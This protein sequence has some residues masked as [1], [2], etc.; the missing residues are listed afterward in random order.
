MTRQVVIGAPSLTG[1][2]AN[3]WV[4]AAFEGV[5][6]PLRLMV[7]NHMPRQ[8]AFPEVGIF[9]QPFDGQATVD[10]KSADQLQRF[11][12]SVEQIAELNRYD[13][14]LT[15]EEAE[16]EPPAPAETGEEASTSAQRPQGKKK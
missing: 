13:M 14:A 12:S 7:T 16:E 1:K 8:A 6:Y 15:L 4:Q 11:T 10:I 3:T 2:D 9:L 5:A